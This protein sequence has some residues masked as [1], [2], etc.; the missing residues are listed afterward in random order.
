MHSEKHMKKEWGSRWRAE[1]RYVYKLT[2]R[3]HS[4]STFS[5]SKPFLKFY[6]PLEKSPQGV[7]GKYPLIPIIVLQ[8]QGYTVENRKILKE[9]Y[10]MLQLKK[11]KIKI[12]PSILLGQRN[13]LVMNYFSQQ[14]R[15]RRLKIASRFQHQ[16]DCLLM[17]VWGGGG[18]GGCSN[19][20]SQYFTEFF[21]LPKW[22]LLLSYLLLH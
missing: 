16:W 15:S 19:E 3:S 11:K 20:I 18:G 8:R 7:L 9:N 21:S 22:I 13:K 1:N 12:I 5:I 10:A 4:I 14:F 17:T 2:E 6:G